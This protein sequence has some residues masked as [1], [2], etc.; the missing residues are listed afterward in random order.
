MYRTLR[1]IWSDESRPTFVMD[2]SFGGVEHDRFELIT[3]PDSNNKV[4]LLGSSGRYSLRAC[5]VRYWQ[6]V[7]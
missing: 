5:D 6:V 3:G 1:E 2:E 7:S 4:V